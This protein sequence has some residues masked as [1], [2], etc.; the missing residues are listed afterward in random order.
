MIHPNFQEYLKNME[1]GDKT[2]VLYLPLYEALEEAVALGAPPTVEEFE[3]CHKQ[4]IERLAELDIQITEKDLLQTINGW[5]FVL[6]RDHPMLII[7]YGRILG[8]TDDQWHKAIE[9]ICEDMLDP[10]YFLGEE[11]VENI[12][13]L[14]K[15]LFGG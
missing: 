2:D 7:W 5:M 15:K 13:L 9:E 12:K 14:Q 4:T 1:R 6:L 8:L 10:E 3:A 11:A